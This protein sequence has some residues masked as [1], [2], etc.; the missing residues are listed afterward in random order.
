[1]PHKLFIKQN[2]SI[3]SCLPVFL[4]LKVYFPKL[5]L[6]PPTSWLTL[7]ASFN[8]AALQ[9]GHSST[10]PTVK[11]QAFSPSQY[12][13]PVWPLSFHTTSSFPLPFCPS[14]LMAFKVLFSQLAPLLCPLSQ[15]CGVWEDSW[16]YYQGVSQVL[17]LPQTQGVTCRERPLVVTRGTRNE[18]WSW[19][20]LPLPNHNSSEWEVLLQTL[21]SKTGLAAFLLD[22]LPKPS[23]FIHSASQ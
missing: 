21:V 16:L 7:R 11:P 9:P 1:M 6:P 8:E 22:G 17:P 2:N 18:E 10:H 13:L 14:A 19:C 4:L 12:P 5:L 3:P 23:L 15:M 20:I